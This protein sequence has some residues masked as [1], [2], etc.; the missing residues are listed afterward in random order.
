VLAEL[1]AHVYSIEILAPL[2][3]RASRSWRDS[4]MAGKDPRRRWLSGLA[5]AAPFTHN[6]DRRASP[7][8]GA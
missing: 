4:G 3:E 6:R 1:G 8:A 5:E 2:R 7:R